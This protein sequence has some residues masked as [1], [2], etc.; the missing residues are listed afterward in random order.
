M[1]KLLR[2]VEIVA[3]LMIIATLGFAQTTFINEI[4]YDNDG[5][6][7]GEAIEI[8]GPAGTD[9]TGWSLVLYNGSTGSVYNT[10]NLSG[11]IADQINGYGFISVSE[12]GIQNGAPD[13]IALVDAT[14][15]V[16]QFLSYEGSFVA[17]GGPADGQSS[18]DIG[19]A[20]PSNTTPGFSLQLAGSGTVYSD[21]AWQAASV[22]TFGTLNTG[23][24]FGTA[25][26]SVVINEFVF[27]HTGSDVA[28]FVEVK[29]S[30]NTDLSEYTLLEIEGDGTGAGVIDEVVALGTTDANGYWTTGM[31]SNAFENGSV[32]LLLVTDFTGAA[33]D[34]LDSDND[35]ILDTLPWS[36]IIDDVAINDG[37]TSDFYYSSVVLAGGYDGISFTPGGASRIPDGTDTD[38]SADWVRNDYDGMGLPG[39]TGTADAGEA[40]NTPGA[41]NEL[42]SV[43]EPLVLVINEFVFNHTGSDVNEFVEVKSLPETDLSDYTLLEIEGDDNAP[44]TIDEVISLGTTDAIG[45]WATGMLSNAFE[46]GS[47]TLLL[48]KDFTGS[49]GDDLDTNDDGVIDVQ[50]W[51][52]IVDEV[53]VSDGGSADLSYANVVLAANF[54]GQ[55]FTPGG[56]SR[57]PD[58]T[59][60]DT[61][62]DWVRNDFN[63]EGLPDF[64]TAV[65]N[66]GDAINTP[67]TPNRIATEPVSLIINEVDADTPG[68]DSEEFIELYDGG[69][70][71]KAL[72]GFVVV[73]YNGN[74]DA[75]YAAYDLDGYSTDENGYFV[76]GNPG[77]LNVDLE[78]YA[79]TNHIQN[80][81]DAVA[82]YEADAMDFPNGTAVT[83]A[84][85]VDALV[86]DSN[87]G[88]DA[89]VLVLLNAGEAQ[90]NESE[91][92]G[93]EFSMQRIPNGSGG[94]RNTSTYTTAIPTPGTENGAEPPAPEVI[95]ITEA[96]AAGDGTLVTISGI[97][98][99]ADQFAGSA[100]IQDSTAGIAIFDAQVHGDGI[101][102]I[103]DSITIS[104]TRSSYNGQIQISPVS[105]VTSHGPAVFP[106][107]PKT[108]TLAELVYY[109]AQLVQIAEVE[110]PAPGSLIFGNTNIVVVDSSGTSG[111]VRIDADAPGL[112]GL[113]QPETCNSVVGVVGRYFDLYQLMPRMKSDLPCA[114]KY[115]PEGADLAVSKDLTLDV[116]TWN[117]EWFGDEG[118]SPAGAD[119]DAIQKDSVKAVLNALDADIYAVEEIS[120][121]ALFAQMVSE[122]NGYDYVLSD[123]TSYPNDGG[124]K[125]KVGFIYKTSTVSVVKTMPLLASLHPYYGG[126]PTPIADYPGGDVTRFYASG[127]LPFL[128]VADITING[129]TKTYNIIDLHAR[130]NSGSDAQ[131]RYDMRK[132]D[133][134]V[135]KDTLDAY[136]ADANLI[137]LGDYNDDV[138][139]TVADIT[140]TT[141]TT[142]ESY[143]ADT[144]DYLTVTKTLSDQGFRS[145]VFQT[146]MIDHIMLTDELFDEYIDGSARVHY[147]FYDSDYANTASDHFPVSARLQLMNLEVLSVSSTEIDCFE[148]SN[149]TATVEVSGGITPYSYIWSDGQTTATAVGLSAGNY[150][151]TVTDA[152]NNEVTA[153]IE[154]FDPAP[155]EVTMSDDQVVFPAY[156]DASCTEV[157][158]VSVSGGNGEYSYLWSTGETTESI[159]V[160]PID[161]TVYYLTVTDENDCSVTDSVV[162]SPVDVTCTT[163]EGTEKIQLCF[164]GK[165]ICVAINAVDE[166]VKN[167]ATL[168]TCG[169]ATVELTVLD[170]FMAYPNPFVDKISIDFK[171]TGNAD[172]VLELYSAGSS[173]IV[174]AEELKVHKGYNKVNFKVTDLASGTYVLRIYGDTVSPVATTLIKN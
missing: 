169:E 130:A 51:S 167:G 95:T 116:V 64:P 62:A 72:D 150:S 57:I 67:G 31:L 81:A 136:Y 123:A 100:Y 132:Y 8:A 158:A 69:E 113:V 151:V 79:A 27:N 138:D 153:E 111:E 68:T 129:V 84:N 18:T 61:S 7:S 104:G 63:G 157:L 5:A 28:E 85:L 120:D 40:L 173:E 36:E 76:I 165:T 156:P 126:D 162:V 128:M 117:I 143:V 102:Q 12:S 144:E 106:I 77:V 47:L 161:K 172:A 170:Q 94:A 99:V 52:E 141:V 109:P 55:P 147:E 11:I 103:G 71:N 160:C 2:R 92:N 137:L 139:V 82:L 115:Q 19:V 73:L 152:L 41:E 166:H 80:G 89:G 20:E 149:G 29:S 70:G 142:Y 42:V 24:E 107:Q 21:F 54:D 16:I 155:I 168:G 159:T 108:T 45:Y 39:F 74:G 34:D 25:T 50:P 6:D 127:R 35:G 17:V 114:D 135:L 171:S 87:D 86:Y 163:G 146:D 30:P 91:I 140:S 10:I 48:V 134:E 145:Y 125:Q 131:L 65:A 23:Q 98:T 121:D 96:R 14:N 93:A 9:L 56:A 53:A 75:S 90:I 66:I 26:L 58:G 78:T 4:H 13:G 118:N 15:S 112:V 22:N 110:F 1:K 60:T 88:D 148:G 33:G 3:F 32:T 44:G 133:V 105:S 122:M 124:V 37:G 59:D 119:A 97:L 101:F 154:L 83:T 43:T 46:N 164:H 38:T 49:A 174:F